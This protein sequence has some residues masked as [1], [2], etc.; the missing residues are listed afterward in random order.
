MS[1]TTG[2]AA[3]VAAPIVPTE[4]RLL[5]VEGL[6]HRGGNGGRE[7]RRELRFENGRGI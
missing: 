2:A 4:F 6:C 5:V 7:T 1:D 3:A